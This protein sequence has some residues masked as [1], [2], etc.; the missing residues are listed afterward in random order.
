MYTYYNDWMALLSIHQ[1]GGSHNSD[2]KDNYNDNDDIAMMMMLMTI[3]TVVN[4]VFYSGIVP[5]L[6]LN[7]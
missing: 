7:A 1:H 4:F 5:P 3:I 6:S 2:K